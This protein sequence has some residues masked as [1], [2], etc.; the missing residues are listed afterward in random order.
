MPN[1]S[2][3]ADLLPPGKDPA[4]IYFQLSLPT[5][6]AAAPLA[7][8]APAIYPTI[9]RTGEVAIADF[10]PVIAV[11]VEVCCDASCGARDSRS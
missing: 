6:V 10:E 3:G 7:E 8:N 4:C 1:P 9:R 11:A 5:A 2:A